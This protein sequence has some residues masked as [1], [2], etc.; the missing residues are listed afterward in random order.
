MN[1][2]YKDTASLNDKGPNSLEFALLFGV[3]Q[4]NLFTQVP[5]LA[6]CRQ[7]EERSG[8]ICARLQFPITN[9]GT[10]L[11]LYINTYQRCAFSKWLPD[12]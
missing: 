4:I 3:I 2:R 9:H 6:D 1:P 8:R 5:T 11:N 12:T 10:V 7:S